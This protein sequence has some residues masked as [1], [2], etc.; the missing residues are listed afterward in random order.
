M[1]AGAEPVFEGGAEVSALE[2]AEFEAIAFDLGAE[3]AGLGDEEEDEVQAAG[4][5]AA[6]AYRVVNLIGAFCSP[7]GNWGTR[8]KD[9]GTV[10]HY[11]GPAV[12]WRAW[13]DP[14]AWIKFINGLHAEVGRFSPGWYFDGVAYHEFIFGTT[15][16]RTRNYGA[17]LPHCGNLEWNRR[18]LGIHVAIG[19]AQ[20]ADAN[21]LRTLAQRH[22]DHLT[23]MG[24]GRSQCKGH[25]EVG[26][27]ACPGP[28]QDDFVRAF[29]ARRL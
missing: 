2:V 17:N 4:A 11:N 13:E 20:R 26:A 8:I 23:A 21:T 25:L 18:A 12:P 3:V 28:L 1:T 5:S 27:S 16:Y 10:Q 19:G 29:R 24:L 6:G 14:V 7:N 22:Q 15:V 9:L